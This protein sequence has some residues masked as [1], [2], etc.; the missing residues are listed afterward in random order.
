MIHLR[1]VAPEKIAHQALEL[2]TATPAVI[3]SCTCA[4]PRAS[5]RVT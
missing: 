5:R 3:T 1:I 2:L 4:P